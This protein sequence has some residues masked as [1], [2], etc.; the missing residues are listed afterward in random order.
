MQFGA[1]ATRSSSRLSPPISNDGRISGQQSLPNSLSKT[2]TQHFQAQIGSGAREFF[3]SQWRKRAMSL[4]CEGSNPSLT[5][6]LL[7]PAWHVVLTTPLRFHLP[8]IRTPF[9]RWGAL[10]AIVKSQALKPEPKH[11]VWLDAE[12][13][14]VSHSN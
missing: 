10:R 1:W 9:G 8:E 3:A 7:I 13:K 6:S 11:R 14:I 12:F 2:N 5:A 4:A